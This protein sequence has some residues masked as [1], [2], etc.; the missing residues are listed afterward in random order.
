MNKT[1]VLISSGAGL[2][3]FAIGAV[4]GYKI[5]ERNLALR[6]EERL[7]KETADMQVFYQQTTVAKKPFKTP[8]E[9][10]ANLIK[11]GTVLHEVT[12]TDAPDAPGRV[13]YHKI[14][15]TYSAEPEVTDPEDEQALQIMFPEAPKVTNLFE[16]KPH[17]I[18][19][20]VFIENDSGWS[21]STLTW[22]V[23]DNVLADERDQHIEDVDGIVGKD[24]LKLFG[25]DSSDPNVVHIRNPRIESE[26]EVVRHESSY[27]REILGMD[28]EPFQRPSGRDR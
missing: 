7:L 27:S 14:A 6:F 16:N 15:K 5:A 1:L 23:K 19:Q 3:G 2:G 11:P 8:E 18:A 13:E 4:V 9:A 21:Q 24:N 22:Y 28:D 10:A 20:E 25:Q 12:L 26:Y 17:V